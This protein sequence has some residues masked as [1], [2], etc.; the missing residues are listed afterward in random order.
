MLPASQVAV[1]DGP[2]SGTS[3]SAPRRDPWKQKN[4]GG[5]F[6]SGA[7]G[8]TNSFSGS[9]RR[10]GRAF[11]HRL[12]LLEADLDFAGVKSE[13]TNAATDKSECAPTALV[14]IRGLVIEPV[15]NFAPMVF[16]AHSSF[17]NL[18]TPIFLEASNHRAESVRQS[19]T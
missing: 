1:S 17:V 7:A 15:S 8:G 12:P 10:R 9:L 16:A 14:S 11:L 18:S 2:L 6:L 13:W 5:P 3:G 4:P 19:D